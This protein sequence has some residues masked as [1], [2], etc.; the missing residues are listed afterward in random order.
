MPIRAVLFLSSCLA[1]CSTYRFADA[2]LPDGSWNVPKLIADLD[3]AGGESLREGIWIPL[4]WLDATVFERS[5]EPLPAGYTLTEWTSSGPVF[6]V[7]GRTTTI[8]DPAGAPIED[9]DLDW[10]LWGVLY[11]AVA[12][13]VATV[14]GQRRHDRWRAGLVF[15]SESTRYVQPQR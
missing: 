13:D 2:K 15:G 4:L 7:G 14:C 9:E 5:E 12:E 8:V 3:A 10:L 1:A 11:H 6:A